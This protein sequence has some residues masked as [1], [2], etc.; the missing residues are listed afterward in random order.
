MRSRARE[1]VVNQQQARGVGT[2]GA[3]MTVD[4]KSFEEPST[5]PRRGALDTIAPDAAGPPPEP[6]APSIDRSLALTLLPA[7]LGV[8]AGSTDIITYLGLGGLFSAHI[9]GNLALLAAHLVTGST[10]RAALILAVPVFVLALGLTRLLAAGL[11][12]A[13]IA[14]LR[15]LLVLQFLL[16]AGCLT[17]SAPGVTGG[18]PLDPTGAW[19]LAA[20]MLAVSA[21]A[22]QNALVQLSLSGA[23]ATAVMTTNVTRFTLD[24]GEVL[25]GRDPG[26]RVVARRRA[27]HTWPAIAGFL[28]GAGG[29][30]AGFA[31]AGLWALGLPAGLALLALALAL[32]PPPDGGPNRSGR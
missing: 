30:A 1:I 2:D 10:A 9:T 25:L 6:A 27:R 16:L 29:G 21:M 7:V 31:V 14:S 26:E 8:I 32:V 28:V 20:G 3:E 19:A 12:A 23:P 17:L 22:V 11:A 13:G 5:A 24:V 18:P 4:V 15:P